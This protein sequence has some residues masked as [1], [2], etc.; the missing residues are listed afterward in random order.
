MSN[1]AQRRQLA[2]EQENRTNQLMR[3]YNKMQRIEMLLQ[4]GIG[5]EDLKKEYGQGYEDGYK[6]AGVEIVKA[7][8]A[9]IALALRETFGY[10]KERIGRALQAVDEKTIY[11]I[12][13]DELIAQVLQD[14]GI[15]IHF[16][17]PV[18]RIEV[19]G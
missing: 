3:Q 5:P 9:A 16:T 13:A 12:G 11:M 7:C 14:C 8:Y 6:A 4:N 18:D 17:E 1:R 10:G 19:K 15:E 2:R